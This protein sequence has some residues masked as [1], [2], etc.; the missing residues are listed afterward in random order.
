MTLKKVL[1]K[2]HFVRK[3]FL[4]RT[5]NCRPIKLII[6]EWH[7]TWFPTVRAYQP[8]ERTNRASVPTER[9]YQPSE[10][11]PTNMPTLSHHHAPLTQLFKIA[12][13]PIYSSEVSLSQTSS[14]STLQV[15]ALCPVSLQRPQR[16]FPCTLFN[17]PSPL[18]RL[19]PTCL[20]STSCTSPTV[21]VSSVRTYRILR[22]LRL[23]CS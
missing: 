1:L 14:I 4:F 5:E 13:R 22:V 16:L 17:S 7:L 23:F 20:A 11:I 10:R 19:P 2:N 21:R 6:F 15:R 12:S 9:A 8:S 18:P 3:G